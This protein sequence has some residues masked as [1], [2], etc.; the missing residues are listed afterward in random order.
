MITNIEIKN[1]AS[2]DQTGQPMDGLKQVNFV[3]GS[4][5]TG[6][7]TISRVID[8]PD[9]FTDCNVTW[10]GGTP[11]EARVY[12]QD[13]VAANFGESN[14]LKGIF[15]LGEDNKKL[16]QDIADTKAQLDTIDADLKKLTSTLSGADGASG[17]KAERDQLMDEFKETCWTYKKKY[18]TT[19]RKALTGTMGKKAEFATRLR[20]E[21]QDKSADLKTLEELKEKAQ[22]VYTDDLETV[23]L[24]EVPLVC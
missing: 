24:F 11:R 1:E 13:F 15:T 21:A 14:E 19:F 18:E 20:K 5:G 9:K 22:S 23:L 6:K 3:F 2:Y 8:D 12:N 17:K 4:N 10:D 16:V 7:T